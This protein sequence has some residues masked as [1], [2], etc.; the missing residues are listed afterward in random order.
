MRYSIFTTINLTVLVTIKLN[1]YFYGRLFLEIEM[2]E[3][4]EKS[5][6]IPCVKNRG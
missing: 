1:S 3:V 2:E 5:T 4:M 6:V